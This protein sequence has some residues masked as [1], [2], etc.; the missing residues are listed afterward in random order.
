MASFGTLLIL[1]LN[2]LIVIYGVI[3]DTSFFCKT[4]IV[5]IGVLFFLTRH[6]C[7]YCSRRNYAYKP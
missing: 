3:D 2:Y 5:I 4:V 7:I 1:T 6:I